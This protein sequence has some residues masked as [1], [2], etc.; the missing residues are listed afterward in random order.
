MVQKF[1]VC[2]YNTSGKKTCIE[3]IYPALAKVSID[4]GIL[5]HAENVYVIPADLG[6]S[7]LGTWTSVY[8]NASKDQNNNASNTPFL[9]ADKS[10]GNVIRTPSN[11]SSLNL[12]TGFHYCG[13]R[14][15]LINLSAEARPENKGIC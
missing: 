6:W 12:P 1:S 9:I 13:Y 4:N 2:N 10:T 15:C 14:G 5:E 7:D 11:K 8:Q 3:R